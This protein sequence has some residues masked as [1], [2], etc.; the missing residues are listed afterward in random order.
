MTAT[1]TADRKRTV[2]IGEVAEL[3]G[4]TPRTIRYYEEIGL[5]H[6]APERGHGKHRLYTHA[7]V[8]RINEVIRL[9]NLL[10]LS[11]EQLAA[12]LEAEEAR[13][14]LRREWHRDPGPEDRHR[15]LT[16][17]L[18][19][20]DGQLRLVRERRDELDRLEQELAAKRQRIRARLRALSS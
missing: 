3:T 8:D 18:G 19:H 13:A 14:A 11:L 5:L 1:E 7:D 9:R 20:I 12:L 10:G 16:E 2:R 15:I 6:G 4:T 17:A